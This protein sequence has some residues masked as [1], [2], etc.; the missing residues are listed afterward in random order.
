MRYKQKLC[1]EDSWKDTERGLTL[2]G[3]TSVLF[4]LPFQKLEAMAGVLAAILDHEEPLRKNG[5]LYFS[6]WLH[7]FLLH[8]LGSCYV[9]HDHVGLLC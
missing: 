7:Q 9:T 2:L 6:F 5:F 4:V 3:K 8:I 1:T